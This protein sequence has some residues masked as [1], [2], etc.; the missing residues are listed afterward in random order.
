L[1]RRG[2]PGVATAVAG[3]AI[4][5]ERTGLMKPSLVQGLSAVDCVVVGKS[6]TIGDMG[7]EDLVSVIP[8][9]IAEIETTCRN[10][11][12]AHADANEDNVGMEVAI[13]YLAP[14]L[15]GANVEITVEVMAIR[16]RTVT[17]VVTVKDEIDT[18]IWGTHSR[19]V[20]DKGKT[21]ERLKAKA[22]K[23]A[24]R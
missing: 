3:C 16:G 2:R 1:R 10:V 18:V 6:K 5:V 24:A 7:D 19:F 22:E 23:L 9:L 17:F 14:V 8:H 21:V 20:V 4:G 11:I 13:K 15:P 12:L